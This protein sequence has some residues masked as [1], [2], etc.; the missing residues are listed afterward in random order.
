VR[1]RNVD[2]PEQQ[3]LTASLQLLSLRSLL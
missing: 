3:Q 1:R 2:V